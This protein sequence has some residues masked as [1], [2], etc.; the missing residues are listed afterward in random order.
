[1]EAS[2]CEASRRA[3]EDHLDLLEDAD[4]QPTRYLDPIEGDLLIIEDIYIRSSHLAPG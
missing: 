2:R 1:V 3:G 4:P